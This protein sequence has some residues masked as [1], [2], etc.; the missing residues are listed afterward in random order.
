MVLDELKS[1]LDS[2]KKLV[3]SVKKRMSILEQNNAILLKTLR[4]F[5]AM[6]SSENNQDLRKLFNSKLENI[7]VEDNTELSWNP[8]YFLINLIDL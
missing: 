3:K 8:K 1:D 2:E 7:F 4:E 6:A 5:L